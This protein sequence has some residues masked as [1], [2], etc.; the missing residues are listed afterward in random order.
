[1]ESNV[2]LSVVGLQ[3]NDGD[4]PDVMEMITEGTYR[5]KGDAH[6]ISYKESEWTG[7]EGTTTTIKATCDEL[8]LIRN[9]SVNSQFIFQQGKKHLSHYD[10]GFGAVTVDILARNVE[11]DIGEHSGNIRLG[12]EMMINEG[13]RIFNDVVMEIHDSH[14]REQEPILTQ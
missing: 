9:G 8:T 14:G 6:Y 4:E 12:Y 10:T 1:M 11:I 13:A 3:I 5:K 7:M 2:I